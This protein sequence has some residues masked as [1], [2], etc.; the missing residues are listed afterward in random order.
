MYRLLGYG[1]GKRFR[2]DRIEATS[3]DC[4]RTLRFFQPHPRTTD[5]FLPHHSGEIIFNSRV[6]RRAR[7][8]RYGNRV[9]VYV[10]R[11]LDGS[12]MVTTAKGKRAKS[13]YQNAFSE[14]TTNPHAL[15]FIC[16][17]DKYIPTPRAKPIIILLCSPVFSVQRLRVLSL[18]HW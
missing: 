7:K 9:Q 2:S 3:Q 15:C 12:E 17:Q 10:K 5:E 11:R 14:P 8:R 6:G 4:L 1:I 16:C 18:C 13:K